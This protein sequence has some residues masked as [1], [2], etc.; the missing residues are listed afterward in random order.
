MTFFP[1][2]YD[3]RAR[4]SVVDVWS[5]EVWTN[6]TVLTIWRPMSHLTLNPRLNCMFQ[7]GGR[8]RDTESKTQRDR[9]LKEAFKVL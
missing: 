3:S 1:A 4:P 9:T 2:E 7:A 5:G 8:V 6:L